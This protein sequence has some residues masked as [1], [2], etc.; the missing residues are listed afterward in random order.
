VD[1]ILHDFSLENGR[2]YPPVVCHDINLAFVDVVIH[3]SKELVCVVLKASLSVRKSMFMAPFHDVIVKRLPH[4]FTHKSKDIEIDFHTEIKLPLFTLFHKVLM[5]G[6]KLCRWRGRSRD[7]NEG[8]N[9]W[10]EIAPYV[11][12]RLGCGNPADEARKSLLDTTLV[13]F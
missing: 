1:S 5:L 6:Y 4:I 11:G 2:H 13:V 3:G 10:R 7:C 12:S 8:V 9:H